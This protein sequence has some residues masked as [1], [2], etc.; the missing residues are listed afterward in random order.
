VSDEEAIEIHPDARGDCPCG[1]KFMASKE[2][3]V[4]YHTFPYCKKFD[5]LDVTEY[6]VY[7]RLSKSVIDGGKA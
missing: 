7:L 6:L 3:P 1:G 2:P 5:E 4:V